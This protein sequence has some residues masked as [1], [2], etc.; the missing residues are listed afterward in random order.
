MDERLKKLEDIQKEKRRI[1]NC[2]DGG[3]SDGGRRY[4]FRSLQSRRWIN[5]GNA[6]RQLYSAVGHQTLQSGD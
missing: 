1:G 2:K 5:D 4:G 3:P 6:S